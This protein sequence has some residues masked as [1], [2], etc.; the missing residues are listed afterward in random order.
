MV[1]SGETNKLDLYSEARSWSGIPLTDTTTLTLANFVRSANFGLDRVIAL[2]MRADGKWQFDDANNSGEVLDVST[3]LVSGT[4][5][6]AIGITWLKIKQVRIKDTGGNWITL[7]SVDR[8]QLNDSQLTADAGDPKH[9]DKLGNY[10]YLH[11]KPNYDSAGGLEVQFQRGASYF[12]YNDTT[13][14]PGFATQFHRLIALYGALDYCEINDLDKR[15][16]KVQNKIT[17]MEAE[18]IEFYSARDTDQKVGLRTSREDYGQG[19]STFNRD[20]F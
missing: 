16:S 2:I 1:L 9:Y 4:Q 18:L 7:D 15:A 6:Y 3:A 19:G 13:K 5:I 11:P 10:L 20:G 17:S 8:R 12:V 14:T